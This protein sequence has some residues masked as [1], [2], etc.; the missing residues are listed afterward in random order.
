MLAMQH[1]HDK[2]TYAEPIINDL[3]IVRAQIDDNQVT[4]SLC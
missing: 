1:L 2:I 3:V 4:F